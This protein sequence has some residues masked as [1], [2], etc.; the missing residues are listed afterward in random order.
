VNGVAALRLHGYAVSN[1]FNIARAALL[2]KRAAFE[3][4]SVRAS[5]EREFLSISPMGKIPVL[6][7]PQG[8]LAETIAILEYLEDTID[9][10]AL[11][12]A[13]AF[14]RARG[15]Q[16]INIVQM[17]IEAP[18][19]A[20]YP[21]VFF[22]GSNNSAIVDTAQE[23]LSRATAALDRLV[24][25]HPFLLG[26][27]LSYADLFAYYCLDIADRVASFVY[28]RPIRADLA[29]WHGWWEHMA[30]RASTRIVMADFRPAFA[31]YLINRRA[32][33]TVDHELLRQSPRSQIEISA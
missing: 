3:V 20:L 31:R 14:L 8:W 24:Q 21:G 30:N 32:A 9:A 12:P 27:M 18:S 28:D 16:V 4:V 10:P 33:Y 1:Y 26:A 6:E 19:R 2:E 15:R 13:D 7:T 22:G 29:A 11:Y 23:T 25:P 5:R 17:Y